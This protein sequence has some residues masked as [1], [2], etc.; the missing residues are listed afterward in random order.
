MILRRVISHFR[1][2]EWTAIGIDFLIV[3]L[4]VFVGLQVQEYS[5]ARSDRQSETE[6]LGTILD[7]V[8]LERLELAEGMQAALLS[9]KAANTALVAAGEPPMTALVMPSSDRHLSDASLDVSALDLSALIELA[10]ISE[11]NVWNPIVV[12]PF[13]TESS[14]AFETLVSAGKLEIV[15]NDALIR[16]LQFYRQLWQGLKESQTLSYREFR[17]QAVYTGQAVGLSPFSTVDAATL[18][19]LMQEHASLKGA[20][21]T[22]SE[23][24]ILHYS[25]MRNLDQAAAV[26]QQMIEAELSP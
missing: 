20:V 12:R 14:L 9:I 23:F 2:Q 24:T 19:R 17:N 8:R 6:I 16:R 25:Q 15:E 21:R 22:T 18:A 26:L 3:V 10:D 13:P 5:S 1:K 7:D 11:A 4:G